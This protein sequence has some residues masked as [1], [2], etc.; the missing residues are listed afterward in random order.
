MYYQLFVLIFL[1]SL[2]LLNILLVIKKIVLMYL[3]LIC[4]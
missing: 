4:I 2:A 3:I 1:Y